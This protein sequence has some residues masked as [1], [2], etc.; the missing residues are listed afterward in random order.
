MR[1]IVDVARRQLGYYLRNCASGPAAG[2]LGDIMIK[3]FQFIEGRPDDEPPQQM[4]ELQRTLPGRLRRYKSPGK[5]GE[6]LERNVPFAREEFGLDEVDSEILL[7]LL[8]YERNCMLEGFADEV[9]S[10]IESVSKTIAALLG[11]DAR[12]AHRRILPDGALVASGVLSLNHQGKGF[13]G[14]AGLLQIAWPLR[15]V[16]FRPYETRGQWANDMLGP[17]LEPSLGWEDFEH[18]GQVRE[19]A[20]GVLAG[21]TERGA[22]GV[23]LFVYGPVGTGKT[24]FCK[25]LAAKC[26]LK[27]WSVG[28]ADEQGGEP[29]RPERLASL[30]LAQH[31]LRHRKDAA[32]L[33]E[34]AE[35]LLDAS[36]CIGPQHFREL[37]G[38]KVYINRQIEQN[39]VP[40]LWTCNDVDCIDPAVLR[41]MTLPIEIDTPNQPVRARI[42]RRIA[43]D[44]GLALDDAAVSRLSSRQASPAVAAN[45][46]RVAVLA[47][48]GEATIDEAV[49]HMLRALGIPASGGI[50]FMPQ[51]PEGGRRS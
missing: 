14:P 50:G 25:T 29:V 33:F 18:L 12:E 44:V 24:E 38:S 32:I 51:R 47:G 1:D 5:S 30:R 41:R 3:A 19:L 11:I 34:E 49:G 15:K 7:L 45:A 46:A 22:S 36:G 48:G 40:V 26:G 27:L 35:D 39:A 16:M 6:S 37:N 2:L 10:R 9:G 21:A 23:N 43:A 13:A 31:L 4:R 17:P 20:A 42:W 28:E 8:R